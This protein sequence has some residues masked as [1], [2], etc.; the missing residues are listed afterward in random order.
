MTVMQEVYYMDAHPGPHPAQ[1]L[2]EREANGK[3]STASLDDVLRA[4][5]GVEL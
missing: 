5:I 4:R 1:T 2:R 3:S